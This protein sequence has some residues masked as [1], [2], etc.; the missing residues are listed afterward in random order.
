MKIIHFSDPHAGAMPDSISAYFDKRIVGTLNYALKRRFL[1]HMES[2]QLGVDFI[3]KEKP[4]VV[5]CTGDLTSTGQPREFDMMLEILNPLINDSKIK[6]LYVPGNHDTYVKNRRCSSAFENA[7]TTLNANKTT[8]TSLPSL[9]TVGEC[10]FILVNEC[11]PTNIFLSTGYLT[12]ESSR[13]IEELCSEKKERPRIILGHFPLRK[14]YSLMGFRHKIY[15]QKKV[16]ELL[17]SQ[18]I[19]LSLC[20]HTH[21]C[22]YDIDGTGRGEIT[23]GS[24]T[25]TDDLNIIE[26]DKQ[27]NS[28]KVQGFSLR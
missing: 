16:V 19:D 3:I 18:Q 6:L 17:N 26:Y 22:L 9:I 4:D 5:V 20:G 27:Q 15:G 7:F 23:A 1:H 25:K 28:F 12:P 13:K 21:K 14:E 11:C 10:D 24:I 2:M 8:P